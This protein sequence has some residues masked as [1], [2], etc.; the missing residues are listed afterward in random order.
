MFSTLMR[1]DSTRGVAES[2]KV[3]IARRD[4]LDSEDSLVWRWRRREMLNFSDV[5]SLIYG[6]K[7]PGLVSG[8]GWGGVGW[9]RSEKA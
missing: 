5:L 8:V 7:E 2:S 1:A 9:G 6:G 3:A 4:C